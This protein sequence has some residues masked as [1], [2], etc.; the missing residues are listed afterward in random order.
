MEHLDTLLLLV[1]Q[2]SIFNLTQ[3]SGTFI[4]GEAIEI[5]GTRE[6]PRTIKSIDEHS[7]RDV[8]SL[9]Q[10]S[11]AVPGSTLS[12][13]FAADTVL[14]EH[15]IPGFSLT[16]KVDINGTTLSSSRSLQGL[17]VG[18]IIS[19]QSG[20]NNVPIF[21]RVTVINDSL[22]SATVADVEDITNVCE[23]GRVNGEHTIKLML[24][25]IEEGGGLY[26][27]LDEPNVASVNL[28]SSSLIVTD[29]SS[30][31]IN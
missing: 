13:D 26:A 30:S 4:R 18:D 8:K 16:D 20:T 15:A 29:Q 31:K 11:T 19:Y 25:V 24:P 23:G 5:N 9:F 21:N 28:G 7:I 14:K 2:D 3:T 22:K 10:N 17:K 12:G 6:A 27:R 1:L